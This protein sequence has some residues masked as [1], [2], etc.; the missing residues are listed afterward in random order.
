LAENLLVIRDRRLADLYTRNWK[1]HEGH[2]EVYQ[3]TVK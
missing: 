1:E 2:S 3:G